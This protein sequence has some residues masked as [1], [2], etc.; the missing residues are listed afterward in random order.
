MQASELR[1]NRDGSRYVAEIEAVREMVNRFMQTEVNPVPTATRSA[2][3]S[4]VT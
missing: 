4:R 1:R 2:A 3:N